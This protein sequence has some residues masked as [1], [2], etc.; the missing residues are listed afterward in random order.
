[1]CLIEA[2]VQTV[3]GDIGNAGVDGVLVA[4][5][6]HGLALKHDLA[7][8]GASHAEKAERQF[9]PARPHQSGDPEDFTPMQA[10]GNILVLT[11]PGKVA[12]FQ[13]RVGKGLLRPLLFVQL[14]ARHQ[15]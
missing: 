4:G 8:G 15:F 2:E 5:K 9:R 6:A 11:G 12:Q 14:H 3:F 7:A 13:H 10:K 1:M